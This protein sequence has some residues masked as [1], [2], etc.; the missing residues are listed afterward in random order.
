MRAAEHVAIVTGGVGKK[1]V[2]TL[3][4]VTAYGRPQRFVDAGLL[5][6]RSGERDPGAVPQ[7]V[8]LGGGS[9][10]LWPVSELSEGDGG[11][12]P[13]PVSNT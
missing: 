11:P 13:M 3:T 5:E 4:I 9:R 6:A 12:G 2:R 1:N 7:L 8:K 10:E